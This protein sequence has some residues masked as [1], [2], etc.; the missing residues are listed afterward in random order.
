[1][2]GVGVDWALAVPASPVAIKAP[3]AT[4]IVR[5]ARVLCAGRMV[6]LPPLCV[7]DAD[8]TIRRRYLS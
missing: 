6:I 8:V 7:S 3:N 1:V 4:P 2:S 5:R